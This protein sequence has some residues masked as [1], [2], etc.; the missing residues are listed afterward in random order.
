MGRARVRWSNAGHMPPL[1]RQ[2]GGSV[3]V[4]DHPSDLLLGIMPATD[5]RERGVDLKVGV[6][7]LL[8]TGGLISG[9]GPP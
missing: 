2:P 8:F 5:R 9:A 6:T 3:Q 7:L 4:L 1:L